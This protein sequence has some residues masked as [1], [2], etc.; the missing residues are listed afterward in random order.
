MK[1]YSKYAFLWSIL[2]IVVFSIAFSKS[3]FSRQ[4]N[5]IIKADFY[6]ATEQWDKAISVIKAEPQYNIMLN[7]FYNRAI[8]NLGVYTDKY[9]DY[10]QLIGTYGIYPDLLDYDMLYMF[11]SDYYFDL[12]YISESQKWAFKY[13]SKYPFCARTLQRLVQTHLIAGDYKIARKMLTILDKNLISKDF[14]QK[15]SD[16]VNDT[17]LI[18]KDPLLLNKRAQMPVNMLTPIKMEDKLL[19]LL[20]KNKEN[21]SAYEHLQMYYLLNHEFGGFMKYLPDA[22]R[23]YSSLPTVFEEALFIIATKQKTDF[24]NYNIK[25]SSKQEFNDFWK[26]MNSYGNNL[27]VAQAKLQ[28]FKNTLYY[29][30]LF[31]SPKVTNKKPAKVTGDEYGH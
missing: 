25:V 14:V 28:P 16:F 9:F 29:Y 21:K 11:Y 8:D 13:L 4:Q 22:K 26:T 5:N 23:F 27:K 17:T 2:I 12:G 30:I 10:P 20:E 18:D 15:Y 6:C 19:D 31:D 7:F 1:W 24:S 3:N